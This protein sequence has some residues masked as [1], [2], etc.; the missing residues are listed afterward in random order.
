MPAT[1]LIVDDDGPSRE[2]L[3][4]LLRHAGYTVL[5]ASD[6]ADARRIAI[7]TV[8][9]VVVSD[10]V[11]PYVDGFELAYELASNPDLPPIGFILYSATYLPS[12]AKALATACGID[13]FLPK[14]SV[15][16]LMLRTIV[17][18]PLSAQRRAPITGSR[19]AFL[20]IHARLTANKLVETTIQLRNQVAEWKAAQCAQRKA[21]IAADN[22][23]TS[24][25]PVVPEIDPR[26]GKPLSIREQEVLRHMASGLNNREIAS[27]LFVSQGTIKTHV[28][29]ILAKI[30]ATDR[31][32][33]AVWAMRSGCLP[34]E[35]V[36]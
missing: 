4:T 13:A 36:R 21:A 8:P 26:F 18:A 27:I 17:D 11:M 3:K 22:L 35:P 1:V 31:F 5:E 14:P 33:A 28:Q 32:K 7:E 20:T 29:H 34:L 2:L 6:G 23:P 9:S 16:T 24:A 12:E 25:R 19:E 10:A 30:G 15:P